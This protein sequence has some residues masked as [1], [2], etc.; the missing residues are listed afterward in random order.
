MDSNPQSAIIQQHSQSPR[1]CGELAHPD[2]VGKAGNH[3]CDSL[4][5]YIRVKDDCISELAFKC[6]GCAP[7]VACGSILTELARGRH[8]D[9]A[10]E[11]SGEVI[12][13]A[14]GG[15]DKD[16]QHCAQLAAEALAN[17]IWSYLA[18]TIE[19][20]FGD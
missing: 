13:K 11:I 6:V 17:A 1:N 8:L 18:R 19:R 10:A 15:L 16:N 9:D 20:N 4:T 14:L 12:A 5:V 3:G 2:G 7:A